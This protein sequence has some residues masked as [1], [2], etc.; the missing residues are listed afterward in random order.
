MIK[1]MD[2]LVEAFEDSVDI[3]GMIEFYKRAEPEQQIEMERLIDAG[4]W[5]AVHDFIEKTTKTHI[6]SF[7]QNNSWRASRKGAS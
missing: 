4:D 2:L 1:L 7:T 6:V 5:K 3:M